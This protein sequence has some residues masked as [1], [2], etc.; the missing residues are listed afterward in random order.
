MQA[1]TLLDNFI[2]MNDHAK[3]D[4]TMQMSMNQ[5]L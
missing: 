4:K 3:N 1:E 2:R 5:I